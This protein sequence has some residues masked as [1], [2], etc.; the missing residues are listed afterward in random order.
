MCVLDF[1]EKNVVEGTKDY[2][3]HCGKSCH[4]CVESRVEK[5]AL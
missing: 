2:F 4:Q 3:K 1:I 5:V